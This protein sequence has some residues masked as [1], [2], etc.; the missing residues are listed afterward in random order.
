MLSYS[1]KRLLTYLA[2]FPLMQQSRGPLQSSRGPFRIT[3]NVMWGEA[4]TV[5]EASPKSRGKGACRKS[6][7]NVYILQGWVQKRMLTIG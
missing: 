3:G 4:V 6:Q 5:G 7:D 1:R 2:G